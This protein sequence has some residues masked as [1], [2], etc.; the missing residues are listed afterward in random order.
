[1]KYDVVWFLFCLHQVSDILI[2]SSEKIKEK[3]SYLSLSTVCNGMQI[4]RAWHTKRSKKITKCSRKL[5]THTLFCKT[6]LFNYGFLDFPRRDCFS[7]SSVFADSKI[8][9][10]SSFAAHGN[11]CEISSNFIPVVSCHKSYNGNISFNY[12]KL[13][14]QFLFLI[15]KDKLLWVLQKNWIYINSCSLLL[16]FC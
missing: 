1:M 9:S 5:Q 13:F 7:S 10:P 11:K 16:I 4:L 12:I 8:S 15:H 14:L 3:R 2:L 6:R